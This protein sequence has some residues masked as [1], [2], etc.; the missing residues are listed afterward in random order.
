MVETRRA[1]Q[2]LLAFTEYTYPQ[3]RVAGH[4]KLIVERLEALERGDIDRLMIFMP[5]RH[6]KSELASIR[7]PA[8]YLGRN[9][10]KFVITASYGHRLAAR[11]GRR[12]RNL[13]ADRKYSDVFPGVNLSEDSAAKDLFNTDQ[14]GQYLATSVEG[15]V[16]GE[17]GHLVSIDDPVKGIK[18]A[19]SEVSQDTAW[20]WYQG[21]LYTRLMPGARIVVTQ[22][23]WNESDLAGRILESEGRVEEGGQWHVLDLPA[24]SA[25]GSALWSD[26]YPIE[27]LERIKAVIG[28]RKFSALYQQQP[29]PDEGTFFQRVWFGEH[30]YPTDKPVGELRYYG[31]SDYAV[32]EGDGDYTVHRIW[33]IDSKGDVKRTAGWRK[34]S[35]SDEW[36]EA[37]LDLIARF[38]PLAWFGEGGVIQ[39]AVEPMIRRRM[40]ERNVHCR[41]EW[42]PSVHDK[43]TRAR[44][45]QALAAS[46][47]VTFERGAD[48]SE[49]LVFPAGKNDDDVDCSSLIGRAIDQAH[50]AIV[51]T[52]P[53]EKPRDAW[54][55]AFDGEEADGWKVA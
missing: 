6:G 17:G 49:H 25:D 40:R 51:K 14:G 16:T 22:T 55:K 28:A 54:D 48:L 30:D 35:A 20:D 32:T 42:L 12:V 11:F 27:T 37:K 24:I 13:I 38:K 1:Q 45:F 5:P 8:W 4:H 7:F 18:E 26:W 46:G 53:E 33:G 39:K 31:T 9:P 15:S 21:D 47:R 19:D 41:L 10:D 23:R 2:S 44:S 36:I 34:Q 50:P 3:Y 43:P 29:Q 52:Q